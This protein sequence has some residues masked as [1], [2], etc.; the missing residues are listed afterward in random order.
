MTL[1]PDP[2][3]TQPGDL[4]QL[5]SPSNKTFTVRLVPGGQ[6][7]T[8][9]GVV[10]FDDLIG[11]PWG[12]EIFSHKGSPFFLLQPALGDLLREMKRATQI[13]YPKDIGYVLVAMGIGPGTTVLEAGTGS[14][15]LTTALAWAVGPQGHVTTYEIRPDTQRLAQKNLERLGLDDRVTFKLKDI[16]E[17]FDETGVDAL[18]LDV[19]N[20]F[21]YI[22]Q[23]RD[24][25]KSGGFF[26]S[27]LPTTNQVSRLLVALYQYDFAFVD[28]CEIILRF[29]KPVPER[30]RPTDRMVAHTGFLIFG[31]PMLPSKFRSAAQEG[32]SFTESSFQDDTQTR[33]GQESENFE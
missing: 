21:D 16:A 2:T 33:E 13:M 4:A 22:R 11:L 32:S 1:T 5:V 15:A 3:H 30:L 20:S 31:R 7:Q 24:A 19:Q 17:G 29:Y 9:R 14:G 28:V 27:I 25:L 10:D 18:F 26:G 6:L 23:A 8:H 12:S